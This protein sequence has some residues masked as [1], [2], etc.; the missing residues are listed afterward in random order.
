M[1]NKYIVFK[2]KDNLYSIDLKMAREIITC[3]DIKQLPS[4]PDFFAGLINLRGFLLPL[5]DIKKILQ[6]PQ[7]EENSKRKIIIIAWQKKIFGLLIDE[8]EDIVTIE[9]DNIIPAP[10]LL[11]T[12]DKNFLIGGFNLND[13]IIFILDIDYLLTKYIKKQLKESL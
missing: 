12:M 4:M 8:I 10:A 5:I 2:L 11:T 6:I 1:E 9:E 7:K 13:K 3:K